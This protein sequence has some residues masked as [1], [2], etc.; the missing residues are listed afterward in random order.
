LGEPGGGLVVVPDGFITGHCAAITL[1]AARSNVPA[2]FWLS[3]FKRLQQGTNCLA[4]HTV[5][6]SY[7]ARTYGIRSWEWQ[8]VILPRPE[9]ARDRVTG[10][11]MAYRRGNDMILL[12]CV[13]VSADGQ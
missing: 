4:V 10:S 12:G 7:P 5:T 8:A 1:A 11:V 9:V 3:D 2:F 6:A 13:G